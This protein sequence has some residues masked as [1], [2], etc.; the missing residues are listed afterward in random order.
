V[1]PRG[2]DSG[3]IRV[4]VVGD[5]EIYR[6]GLAMILDRRAGI[7]VVGTA[8]S[9][10]EAV[11]RVDEMRPAVLLLDMAMPGSL[12]TVQVLANRRPELKTLALCVPEVESEVIACA[13]AG[14]AGYVTR[15]ASLDDVVAA[16]KTAARGESI[17]SPRIVASLFRRVATLAAE[18][19]REPTALLTARERE[20]AELI[21]NGLSNKEIAAE[22][23]IELPTVKNHV[24]NI[25]EKL[26]VH[27]RGEA[28][29]RVRARVDRPP[30]KATAGEI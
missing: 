7:D 13:E 30:T 29:A 23:Q 11:E 10:E 15:E 17:C 9:S 5:I 26:G 4:A 2:A 12:D 19:S 16:V 27:R 28:A 3:A 14:V 24:H 25:L 6:Q 22:L 20:V 18:R 1:T 21:N 8:R